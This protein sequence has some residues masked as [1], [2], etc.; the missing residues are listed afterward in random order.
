M[1]WF[2]LV[3]TLLGAII[4]I[5]SA[6]II[7]RSKFTRER[8]IN[9]MEQ[10][11]IVYADYLSSLSRTRNE[12]R[13]A[14]HRESTPLEERIILAEEAFKEGQTYEL[15]YHVAL[16]APASLVQ[17]SDAAFR[18]LR[19]LR[20]VVAA[21][22]VRGQADYIA[23]RDAWEKAFGTLRIAMRQDLGIK[24]ELNI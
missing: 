8:Q 21:G 4:G 22:G 3:S 1:P 7:E 16:L 15:R 10:R 12:L 14:A 13:L 6:L 24:D 11:R 20:D 17:T 19:D 23:A 18:L 9:V 5:G 2:S